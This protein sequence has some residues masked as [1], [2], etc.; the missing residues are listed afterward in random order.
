MPQ[1]DAEILLAHGSRNEIFLVEGAADRFFD[2]DAEMRHFVRRMN[3][4]RGPLGGGDGLYFVDDTG[5]V[6]DIGFYNA[7]GSTSSLCGNGLRC[8]MRLLM[9]RRGAD[10]L[11]VRIGSNVFSG[12]RAADVAPGVPA[13]AL[14]LPPVTFDPARIP[15]RSSGEHVDAVVPALHPTLRF[16]ALAVPNPHLVAMVDDY[17]EDLLVD[18]GKRIAAGLPLF[19]EGINLSFVRPLASHDLFVRTFERGSGLTP[20]CGSGNVAS[21]VVYSRLGHVAAGDRVTVRNVGGAAVSWIDPGGQPALEGNGTYQYR[22]TV[23]VRQVLDGSSA[24]IKVRPET[25]EEAAYAAVETA[26]LQTLA[27]AGIRLP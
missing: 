2:T 13:V 15:M 20:S 3:D 5:E 11:D 14:E 18:L 25:G 12:R 23:S 27:A 17:D 16:T 21:R 9:E 4:R 8:V 26:N 24:P 1:D 7:D 22:A 6:P 19:P 10:H